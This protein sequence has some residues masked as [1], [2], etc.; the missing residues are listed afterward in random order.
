M[1]SSEKIIS[2]MRSLS[3]TWRWIPSC[4]ICLASPHLLLRNVSHPTRI[5]TPNIASPC[6]TVPS[7]KADDV[8]QSIE[9]YEITAEQ[10]TRI[11][12]VRDHLHYINTLIEQVDIC[13][14]TIVDKYEGCIVLLCTIPGVD[15]SSAIII[16][17]EIGVDMTQFGFSKRLC[18]WAVL[19]QETTNPPGRK[20]CPYF[21][22]WSLSQTRVGANCPRSREGQA[23]PLL[24]V[25]I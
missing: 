2:R 3:A 23:I 9:E 22:R 15:R 12:I 4:P 13:I 10:K 19:S 5:L 8:L 24:C 1:K 25:Q 11:R 20:I 17:S 6:C 18:C 21:T 14:N 16:L 7:K